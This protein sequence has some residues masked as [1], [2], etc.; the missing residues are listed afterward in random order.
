MM[1][2][3]FEKYCSNL[4]D[5]LKDEKTCYEAYKSAIAALDSVLAGDYSRDRAKDVSLLAA[6]EANI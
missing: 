1:S 4:V 3:K 6:A 2:N 5:S